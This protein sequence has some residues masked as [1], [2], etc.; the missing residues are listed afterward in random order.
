MRTLRTWLATLSAWQRLAW[1]VWAIVAVLAIG[2]AFL[3]AHPRHAGCYAVFGEAGRHWLD[4]QPLY[5]P[6]DGLDVFRYSPLVAVL[7]APLGILPPVAGSALLRLVNLAVY[8]IGV[9]WWLR[10]VLPANLTPA[11]RAGL[12]L[13]AVPLSA[14]SLVDV[15]T[16]ALTVGLLLMAL[17]ALAEERWNWSAV[18]LLLGCAIKVYPI[19]LALLLA[20]VFP[21]RLAPRLVL[22]TLA[23]LALPFCFQRP[24]FVAS[25]YRDWLRWGLNDRHAD[26]IVIAFRDL[27]LLFRV[28][29]VPLSASAYLTLQLGAAVLIA[30]LSLWMRWSR[31]ETR[32]L[33]TAIFGLACGWMM[34][35][36]PATEHTTHIF[37]APTVAWIV[38][39]AFL[40]RHWFL[41]RAIVLTSFALYTAT[42]LCLWFPGGSKFHQLAPHPIAG[43]LLLG[44]LAGA[45]MVRLLR[46]PPAQPKRSESDSTSLQAA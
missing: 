4:G 18:F 16:N 17:A 5:T 10:S 45:E 20:A 25:Q 38:L 7:F 36:G 31:V 9:S 40:H 8:L 39:D 12:F 46:G 15:Q 34:V 27:R 32:R 14:H 28:W 33:L 2:R 44:A 29:L 26:N 11:Q 23:V 30:A 19:S 22:A 6:R 35:F 41:H 24:D 3:I 21:R 43:L 42:Q 37:V 13:L 1:L